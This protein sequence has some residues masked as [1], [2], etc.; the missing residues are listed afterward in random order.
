MAGERG[1]AGQ[2]TAHYSGVTTVNNII[3]YIFKYIEERVLKKHLTK[4]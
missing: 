2:H 4:K 1:D 3:M